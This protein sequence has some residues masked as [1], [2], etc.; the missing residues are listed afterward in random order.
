VRLLPFSLSSLSSLLTKARTPRTAYLGP[1]IYL[2][3][4]TANC[5]LA[6]TTDRQ[7]VHKDAPW[8]HPNCPYMLNTNLALSDFVRRFSFSPFS[9]LPFVVL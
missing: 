2:N 8:L 7:P 3:L 6:N 9:S 4:I 1:G 5:A